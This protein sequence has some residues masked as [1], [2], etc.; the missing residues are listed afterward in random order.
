[1]VILIYLQKVYKNPLDKYDRQRF[2]TQLEK[3]GVKFVDSYSIF[4]IRMSFWWVWPLLRQT[5]KVPLSKEDIGSI[6]QRERGVFV[7]LEMRNNLRRL[8]QVSGQDLHFA[9]A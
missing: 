1:M 5:K 9:Y 2:Q 8:Q 4:P 6:P 7:H 3:E